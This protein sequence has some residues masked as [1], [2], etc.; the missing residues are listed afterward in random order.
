MHLFILITADFGGLDMHGQN[1]TTTWTQL[2][3]TADAGATSITLQTDV[4]WQV[5]VDTVWQ[6]RVET[7]WQVRAVTLWR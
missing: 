6:M 3:S 5:R 1:V 2:A 7:V 4:D